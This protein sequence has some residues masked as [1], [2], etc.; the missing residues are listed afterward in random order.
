MSTP[1]RRTISK[2]TKAKSRPR[3]MRWSKPII[4][5]LWKGIRGR[6]R[7]RP[8]LS[9]KLN[10]KLNL[11]LHNL[12][13]PNPL[14]QKLRLHPPRRRP[15]RR[16]RLLW[17]L[18]LTWTRVMS[19]SRKLLKQFPLLLRSQSPPSPNQNLQLHP[20]RLPH[21]LL[22]KPPPSKPHQ[23]LL[24]LLQQLPEHPHPF[25]PVFHPPLS[26]GFH[27]H[28]L[29]HPHRMKLMPPHHLM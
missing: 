22:P 11:W 6:E 23:K 5:L 7:L 8:K 27:H 14:L 29:L 25:H 24:P 19:S 13:L 20:P 3:L 21:L 28:Q 17:L 16:G 1:Q 26:K 9:P 4:Y 2:S 10:P 15:P 12:R 18:L